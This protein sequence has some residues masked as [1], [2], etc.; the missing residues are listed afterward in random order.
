MGQIIFTEFELQALET[1]KI[2]GGKGKHPSNAIAQIL[3]MGVA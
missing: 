1:A 3:R 2:L